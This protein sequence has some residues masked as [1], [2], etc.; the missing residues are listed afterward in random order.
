LIMGGEAGCGGGEK[1]IIPRKGS[2]ITRETTEGSAN[3]QNRDDLI[4]RKER[5]L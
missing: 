5:E 1:C 2:S 3:A 4:S